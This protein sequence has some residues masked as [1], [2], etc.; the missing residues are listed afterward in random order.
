MFERYVCDHDNDD[1]GFTAQCEG[2]LDCSC[3]STTQNPACRGE[4][5]MIPYGQVCRALC[6]ADPNLPLYIEWDTLNEL[7]VV[8]PW[9]L[10]PH[11]ED[12]LEPE[13]DVK[14]KS[15]YGNRSD[16][17]TKENPYG[18]YDHTKANLI[19][20]F[21]YS[22]KARMGLIQAVVAGNNLVVFPRPKNKLKPK[23]TKKT[24]NQNNK[25]K[26]KKTNA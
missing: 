5:M 3:T 7:A 23:K 22:T 10:Q 9:E 19:L 8:F 24:K 21:H 13:E 4:L 25:K 6:F 2:K 11:T 14:L 26:K 18:W 1:K 15:A 12:A 17:E 20:P 16:Y